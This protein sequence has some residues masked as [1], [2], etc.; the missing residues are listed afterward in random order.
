MRMKAFRCL[1]IWVKAT[2]RRDVVKR[3]MFEDFMKR[4]EENE[5]MFQG[6]R[7]GF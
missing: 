5:E 6:I 1:D 2:V 4:P 7:R 3:V